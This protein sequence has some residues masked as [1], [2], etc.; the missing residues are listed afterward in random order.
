VDTK[1]SGEILLILLWIRFKRQFLQNLGILHEKALNQFCA[2]SGTNP[3]A[4]RNAGNHANLSLLNAVRITRPGTSSLS[5]TLYTSHADTT[6]A[7][8]TLP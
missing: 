2:G 1:S 6:A 7:R 4:L 8:K 5:R 3:A